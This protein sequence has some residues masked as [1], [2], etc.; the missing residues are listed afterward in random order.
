VSAFVAVPEPADDHATSAFD[1][2]D[3]LVVDD[4]P[5]NLDL[6]M[7]MLQGRGY[8][9]RVATGGE[10]ALIV[11][12]N[13]P[14]DV[15]MLDV[16]MPDLDGY[17]VCRR[18][19][20]DPVTQPV[21]VIF[22]SAQDA[23]LDKVRAFDVGGAD[24][25]T[26][27]FQF[28]EVL[29]RLD[30]QLALQRLQ[31]EMERKNREL[32]RRNQELTEWRQRLLQSDERAALIFS[33]LSETL[34]GHVLDG[35]Y[36]LKE[37]IGSGGFGV[38]Y[39]AVHLGL[40][41]EVAVKVF[42]PSAANSGVQGNL[43]RFRR[44]GISACRVAHPH[45]VSVLDSGVT[46]GGIPYLVMEL[47]S[48]RT[49]AMELR[50]AGR[51]AA[52][53]CAEIVLPVVEVL[54]AAHEAGIIHRDVKPE[55][56]VLHRDPAGGPEVVKVV[57]F[58]LAKLLATEETVDDGASVGLAVGSLDYMAPERL[59]HKPY[60]G[61]SDVYSV[62]VLLYRMLTGRLPFEDDGRSPFAVAARHLTDEPAPLRR[63]CP[64]ADLSPEVE[65][66]VMSALVKDPARRPQA[67]ALA[68]PLRA[69][70]TAAGP[71][72]R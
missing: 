12:R 37:K 67:R 47:L 72:R 11:A 30:H 58:G 39:R 44:E 13:S 20:A 43:E 1:R 69:A 19:K 45:A 8:R 63:A 28:E 60:D 24:Y 71:A 15:I 66:V 18:L 22:V 33:A 48:G 40:D 4:T 38:V 17:E 59:R 27:P 35:R 6:L 32:E 41:R 70:L 50:A 25:V 2:A 36:R 7:G 65:A 9:V 23:V 57:D 61:R 62:G 56:I 53:R 14:P 64:E 54:A 68:E 34:P 16:R 26:K 10:R 42:Q 52:A 31:R 5:A 49:L 55:N 21:P 46:E 51:L 29:A 3:I